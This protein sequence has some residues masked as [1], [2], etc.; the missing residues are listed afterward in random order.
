MAFW[1]TLKTSTK[2]IISIA[3]FIALL[4]AAH[5]LI[6][7]LGTVSFIT[8]T[9]P[10]PINSLNS[11]GSME[12]IGNVFKFILGLPEPITSQGLGLY[13]ATFIII[14]FTFAEIIL[15]LSFFSETT[16]WIIAGALGVISGVTGITPLIAGLFIGVTALGALGVGIIL[17]TAFLAAT[18]LHMGMGRG[19]RRWRME[20]QI[21]IESLK[22]GAGAASVSSAISGLKK[23]DRAFGGTGTLKP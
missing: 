4:F 13:F 23:V 2:A 20:R 8:P 15:T 11:E 19:L 12:W 10:T 9:T 3:L 17:I 14:L 7:W 21:E 16:S 5:Y 18:T 1:S 22:S 6:N